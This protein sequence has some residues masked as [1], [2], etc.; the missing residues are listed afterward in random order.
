MYIIIY[1]NQI[2]SKEAPRQINRQWL[3][4][5]L[6]ILARTNY[7]EQATSAATGSTTCLE[8]NKTTEI[9]ELFSLGYFNANPNL[10]LEEAGQIQRVETVCT[11]NPQKPNV[12]I[13]NL[14]DI[15]DHQSQPTLIGSCCAGQLRQTV[16]RLWQ[17]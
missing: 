11:V 17:K 1:A 9:F 13:I 8:F 7:L 6:S 2:N 5:K 10:S 15:S 4:E 3:W 12:T 16:E 14:F